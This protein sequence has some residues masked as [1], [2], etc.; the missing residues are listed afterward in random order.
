MAPPGCAV[1]AG[2]ADGV[3][4]SM[5]GL[6][7]TAGPAGGCLA[8]AGPEGQGEILTLLLLALMAGPAGWP[9]VGDAGAERAGSAMV[10]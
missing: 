1:A 7:A 9:A 4:V 10:V 2:P 6:V 3:W 5:A 8:K